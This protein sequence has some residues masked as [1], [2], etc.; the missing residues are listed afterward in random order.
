M[1][2]NF[3]FWR[4]SYHYLK[5]TGESGGNG[6]GWLYRS[7]RL[8]LLKNIWRQVGTWERVNDISTFF[9]EEFIFF[10]MLIFTFLYFILTFQTILA[11][12]F[13]DLLTCLF[14]SAAQGCKQREKVH[15]L[16]R[17]A[18]IKTKIIIILNEIRVNS[19]QFVNNR[20]AAARN[21][22]HDMVYPLIWKI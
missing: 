13:G 14:H 18:R 4:I 11:Y 19:C 21:K 8:A 3:G 2:K 17:F 22:I 20:C 12:I 15:G 10:L 1:K 7:A 6:A 5:T 9:F 16:H